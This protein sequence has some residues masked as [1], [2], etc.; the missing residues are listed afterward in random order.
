[1]FWILN[2]S[3]D[4]DI[5][6]QDERKQE[7][8]FHRRNGQSHRFAWVICWARK[9]AVPFITP[10]VLHENHFWNGVTLLDLG[11]FS[12]WV[13]SI[14]SSRNSCV[15]FVYIRVYTVQLFIDSFPSYF[16]PSE[17]NL[18]WLEVAVIRECFAQSAGLHS[19]I[20]LSH[21]ILV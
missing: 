13:D 10:C 4:T 9:R 6:N 3:I 17:Q 1:M 16:I 11:T 8:C 12:A 18:H 20:S 21:F 15:D 5:C 14:M 19:Q 7:M 2:A